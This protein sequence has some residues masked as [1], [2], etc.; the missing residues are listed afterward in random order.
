MPRQ[1]LVDER[2]VGVEQIHQRPILTNDAVEEELGFLLK[3]ERERVAVVR[4]QERIGNDVLAAGA[5]RA[6]GQRSSR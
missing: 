2:V 6:T 5:A 4:I 3:R 1:P